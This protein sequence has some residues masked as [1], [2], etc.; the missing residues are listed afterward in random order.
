MA[1]STTALTHGRSPASLCT[2]RLGQRQGSP[3]GRHEIGA[4]LTI[5]PNLIAAKT[6]Y[7][8]L[9]TVAVSIAARPTR[10]R[11]LAGS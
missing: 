10:S 2:G 4:T 11:R 8:A 3:G 1:R 9:A 7:V 5:S 6:N